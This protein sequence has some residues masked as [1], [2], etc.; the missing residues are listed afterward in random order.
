MS[1]LCGVNDIHLKHFED[2]LGHD[3]FIRGNELVVNSDDESVYT[4]FKNVINDLVAKIQRGQELDTAIIVSAFK[5]FEI[6]SSEKDVYDKQAFQIPTGM[7]VYPRN[8]RQ[9]IYMRGMK[10]KD[11]AIGIG[12]AGTGKTF[13]AVACAMELLLTRQ[14]K[15]LVITRPV[16]EAGESLGFLPGDLTQKLNPY[17]RPLYDAMYAVTSPETV[18]RLEENNIIEVAPLAYMRGR[19]LRDCVILLDEAQNTTR[20]QMLMFLTRMGEN[21]RAFVTGDVTQVDLPKRSGSGL[22]HA[23]K[24]I[25]RIPEIHITHFKTEDVVRNSLVQKI[26]EAYDEYENE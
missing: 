8:H 16:V 9:A 15:R 20:E 24:I 10:T 5:S 2:L 6:E 19:S 13:L 17:L 18:K 25:K 14:V 11:L 3:V 21:C 7:T 1:R 12:P 23:L 22:V 4:S 26:I